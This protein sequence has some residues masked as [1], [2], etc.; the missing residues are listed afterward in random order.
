MIE[1]DDT[2]VRT[3]V[4]TFFADFPL[5][6]YPKGHILI[7]AGENPD[8][9]FYTV[10]GRVRQYDVS[11]RGDEVIV[12][13]FKP[14]SFFP[15]SWAINRSDNKYFFKT[16]TAAQFRVA[17]AD[18]VME[19]IVQNPDVLLDLLRRIYRGIEG[20]HGRMVHLM[21]GTARSRLIHELLGDIKRFGSGDGQ[22]S[23]DI[24]ATETDLAARSGLARETVSRELKKL[25]ASG[26]VEVANNTIHIIDLA[27]LSRLQGEDTA[28]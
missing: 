23:S 5:R 20:L 1:A 25:K 16:E 15:M 18:E 13:M 10:E 7:F 8:Y 28:G 4:D 21:S 2:V 22:S 11:Y 3:K 26:L 12:N 9:I 17:P 24:T 14:L 6:K 19:F 27:E